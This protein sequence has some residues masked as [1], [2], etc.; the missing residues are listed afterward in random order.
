M[1]FL[2]SL[3]KVEFSEL[4]ID[5]WCHKYGRNINFLNDLIAIISFYNEFRQLML[6]ESGEFLP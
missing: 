4:E 5:K 2:G 6:Q 3:V 1:N